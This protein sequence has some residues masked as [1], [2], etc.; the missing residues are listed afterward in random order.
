MTPPQRGHFMRSLIHA[1]LIFGGGPNG[2]ASCVV[3]S[4]F[5]SSHIGEWR[6]AMPHNSGL[7]RVQPDII[8]N[9]NSVA[10][11][12]FTGKGG[13]DIH[14]VGNVKPLHLNATEAKSLRHYISSADGNELDKAAQEKVSHAPWRVRHGNADRRC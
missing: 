3:D 13:I 4:A 14:F 2:T 8:V 11:I 7:L 9:I 1:V 12:E 10:Y 6:A 5:L